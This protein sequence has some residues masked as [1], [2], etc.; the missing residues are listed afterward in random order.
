MR[1]KNSGNAH[2]TS[3]SPQGTIQNSIS[4]IKNSG[5]LKLEQ[6]KRINIHKQNKHYPGTKE[7]QS[8]KSEITL[9][10]SECQQLVDNYSGKGQML[11]SG[12]ERVDFEKSIGYYVD[13]NTG[14][15]YETTIGLI[16][17]SNSGSHIIPCRPKGG[18]K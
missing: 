18:I 9:T 4:S 7:F 2:G 5:K 11:S 16:V 10:I 12:K 14:R 13:K 3:G 8:G 17:Y 15:K 6:I 1:N